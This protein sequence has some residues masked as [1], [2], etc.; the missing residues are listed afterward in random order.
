VLIEPE[1]RD[2]RAGRDCTIKAGSHRRAANPA[3]A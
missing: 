1:S 2:W 3:V